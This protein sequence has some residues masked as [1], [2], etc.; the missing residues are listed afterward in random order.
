[1]PFAD[2][3]TGARLHYLD[4]AAS[5]NA[6][7]VLLIHGFLGTGET[8]FPQIIAWLKP[9]YRVI[10]PTLRGWGQSQPKPRRF[11]YDFYQ[12]DAADILALLDTLEIPRAV[13]L[14]YSDGGE[15]A[16][17]AA[18]KQPERFAAV[19]VWGAIGYYGPEMRPHTQ[20]MYPGDWISPEE[21]ALHGIENVDAFVLE[22]IQSVRLIIDS[23]GDLSL[24]LAPKITAPLLLMLGKQDTLNPIKYGQAFVDKTPNGR[25]A[26]FE[27]GHPIHQQAWA[28]FQR[29]VGA[30]LRPISGSARRDS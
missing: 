14:G 16:L 2:L 11:P 23:G 6:I 24:S 25:L 12:Q 10:A 7:P 15:A 5:P 30:F 29:V 18:G 9:D 20:R 13:I 21:R 22:W 28:E 4:T 17:L 27:C 26:T 3:S 19:A 1:M 8:E